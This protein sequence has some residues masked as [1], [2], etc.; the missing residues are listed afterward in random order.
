[1][2]IWDLPPKVLCRQHLLAEHRELH[3][4]W[5]VITRK[6]KGYSRHPETLRWF[7]HLRALFLRHKALVKEMRARGYLHRSPLDPRKATGSAIQ[8]SKVDSLS[9]QRGILRAKKCSCRV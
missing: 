7:G 1:M 2:R 5:S 3:A 4:V 9:E 6:K 8:R